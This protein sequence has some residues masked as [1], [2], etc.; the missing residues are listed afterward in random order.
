MVREGARPDV[1]ERMV[2]RIDSMPGP[3]MSQDL[4]MIIEKRDSICPWRSVP[5][6]VNA[7]LPFVSHVPNLPKK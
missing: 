2:K 4:L 3:R 5:L 6:T 1:V 7:S